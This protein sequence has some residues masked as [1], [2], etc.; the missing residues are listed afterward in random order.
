MCLLFL[1]FM[2]VC[3][4]IKAQSQDTAFVQKGTYLYI[5]YMF[6]IVQNKIYFALFCFF[7]KHDFN[8]H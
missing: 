6:L 2:A 4:C 3:K 7:D 8:H 1:N 5:T